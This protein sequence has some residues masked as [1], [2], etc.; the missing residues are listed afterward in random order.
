MLPGWAKCRGAPR[1][2]ETIPHL[3]GANREN[4][5]NRALSTGKMT[6]ARLIIVRDDDLTHIQVAVVPQHSDK[7]GRGVQRGRETL[8][9]SIFM[10]R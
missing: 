5:K 1:P 3:L 4:G 7:T 9:A 10:R 8:A 6:K 2:D